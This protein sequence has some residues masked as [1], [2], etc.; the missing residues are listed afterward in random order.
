MKSIPEYKVRRGAEFVLGLGT[1]VVPNK[2][3]EM[4]RRWCR[5]KEH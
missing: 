1:K 3:K 4:K 2:K 5:N